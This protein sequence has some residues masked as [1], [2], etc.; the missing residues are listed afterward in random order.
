MVSGGC[1]ARLLSA[2]L[3]R[4][5]LLHQE[6]IKNPKFVLHI[7]PVGA[8]ET[9]LRFDLSVIAD[10]VSDTLN[11]WGAV[12]GITVIIS[13]A[14]LTMRV[15]KPMRIHICRSSITVLLGALQASY[16][17]PE[18]ERRLIRN[19]A[20]ENALTKGLERYMRVQEKLGVEPP[21]FVMLTLLGVAGYRLD[22]S[23]F[24]DHTID[25]NDL[26]IPEVRWRNS[27]RILTR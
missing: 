6:M 11:Q 25:R 24:D 15:A 13:M 8:F 1:L 20:I 23:D 18:G 27:V 4:M 2:F 21:L 17:E 10:E 26:I 16:L 14:S 3:L 22:Q 12:G 9:G 19:T 7:I 5:P